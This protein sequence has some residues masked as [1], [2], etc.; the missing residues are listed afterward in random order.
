[1]RSN[2]GLVGRCE[3]TRM[4]DS[5]PCTCII[6]SIQH[7]TLDLLTDIQLLKHFTVLSSNVNVHYPIH[8]SLLL[9]LILR[10]KGRTKGVK[11]KFCAF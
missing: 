11:L 7:S 9:V 3:S 8:N 4:S 2:Q 10:Q 5:I 6:Y 1:M